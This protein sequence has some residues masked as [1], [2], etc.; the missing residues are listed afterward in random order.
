MTETGFN[1]TLLIFLIIFIGSIILFSMQAIRPWISRRSSWRRNTLWAGIYLAILFTLLPI[2]YLLPRQGFMQSSNDNS[3][4]VLIS[5]TDI[6]ESFSSVENPDQVKGLYKNNTQTF[7]LDSNNI[8]FDVSAIPVN[9]QIFVK[10]KNNDDGEIEVRSYIT[11]RLAGKSNYAKNVSPPIIS[12]KN[13]RLF[14][15]NPHEQQKLEFKAFMAD[16]TIDQFNHANNKLMGSFQ[17][18]PGVKIL[19]LRVPQS[20][21]LQ[22]SN[23]FNVHIL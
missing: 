16:F 3:Q 5:P 18:L 8:T 17:T 14:I 9:Y 2:H 23:N 22:N 1:L 11:D 4:T 13:G 7:K 6:I 12:L 21:E 15:N 20:L 19:Y 10:R